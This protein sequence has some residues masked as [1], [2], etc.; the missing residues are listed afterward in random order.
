MKSFYGDL[1]TLLHLNEIMDPAV[2]SLADEYLPRF[3][4]G[5]KTGSHVDLIPYDG[6]ISMSFGPNIPNGHVTGINPNTDR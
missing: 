1:A 4:Q 3:C 5:F 6:V 2:G